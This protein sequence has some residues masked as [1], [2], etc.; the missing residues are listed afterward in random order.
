M[1]TMCKYKDV[2]LDEDPIVV[3]PCS[4]LLTMQSLDGVMELHTAYALT[5]SGEQP[6]VLIA[7]C[8]RHEYASAL[9]LLDGG[10]HQ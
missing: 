8:P 10:W 9:H 3:L 2:D 6:S 1:I 5:D 7:D 4:H